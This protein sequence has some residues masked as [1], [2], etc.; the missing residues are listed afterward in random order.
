VRRG[1][2]RGGN[3]RTILDLR[4]PNSPEYAEL[5]RTWPEDAV[6]R[7]LSAVWSGYD[8]LATEVLAQID[9]TKANEELERSIT[10]LLEPCIRQHLSGNEPYG[11]QHERYEFATRQSGRARSPQ[12]DI[13]FFLYQNPSIMW[14]LE[15]QVSSQ[16]W[17]GCRLCAGGARQ[18][19]YGSL[20]AL[21]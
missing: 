15:A 8:T 1:Q 18:F 14:P 10:Q 21:Y 16:R 13:A 5:K 4:W 20:R 12:Y 11:I 6:N 7:M 17:C 2:H 3:P 19:P 9:V